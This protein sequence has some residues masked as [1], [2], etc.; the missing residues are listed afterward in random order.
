MD[1]RERGGVGGWAG[2]SGCQCLV[3]GIQFLISQSHLEVLTSERRRHIFACMSHRLAPSM[4][5]HL[6]LDVYM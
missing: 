5:A 2:A 1:E 6:P 4:L 3:K